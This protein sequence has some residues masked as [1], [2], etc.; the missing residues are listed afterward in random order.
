MLAGEPIDLN[1]FFTA[2]EQ[3]E[4]AAAFKT[5]GFGSLS[6]VFE[7]LGGRYEYGRLR[8]FRG[9]MGRP[10]SQRWNTS[11]AWRPFSADEMPGEAA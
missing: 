8:L 2:E 5:I 4:V 3:Q 7:S 1:Q 9:A 11:Q 10:A 6:A